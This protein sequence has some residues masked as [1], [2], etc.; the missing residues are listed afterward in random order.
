M[1]WFK[2]KKEVAPAV[3]KPATDALDLTDDFDSAQARADYIEN[4]AIQRTAPKAKNANGAAMDSCDGASAQYQAS[5]EHANPHL[6]SYFIASSS[7]IGYHACALIAQHWLVAKGCEMKA[8]DAVKKGWDIGVNDGTDL[9]AKQIKLIDRLDK[10]YKLKNNMFEAVKFRN[11]FGVRHVLFKHVNPSF[12]YEKPFNADSF[13]NGNYAGMSQIDPYWITPVF[14]NDDLTDP[15]SIGFYEPTY[16]QINGKK[17]HKSHFVVLLGDEVSDYLKPTYRYG[18][19]SLAQKVY[20]RVYAAERTAN[21]APQLAMTKRLQVRKTD[22]AKAQANKDKFVKNLKTA[23]DYRDNFGVTVVGK[24]E[25]INQL[26]TSLADLDDVIMTQYQLVCA[27]FGVPATK[28][29]GTMPKGFSGGGEEN[30]T[31][32]E[33]VEEL[34]GN[35]MNEIAQAHYERLIASELNSKFNVSNIEIELIWRPLKIMSEVELSTVR[36]NNANADAALFN[37]GAIDNIDI[38]QKLIN[39]KNSGYSGMRMPD[40]IEE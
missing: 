32:L 33:D 15:T 23:N 39:D 25:E 5:F 1:K 17:Y 22:L 27:E 3:K 8:K 34:Q 11:I 19:I 24:D 20:E 36:T 28:M 35:D 9:D 4:N 40:E 6:L 29:L 30:D 26:E 16:W 10:K 18:G 12:D 38:R 14:D 37:T 31:Y 13:K 21:E 7:F 2:K